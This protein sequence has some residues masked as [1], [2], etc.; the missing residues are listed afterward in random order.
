MFKA[1][2]SYDGLFSKLKCLVP[3]E[4]DAIKLGLARVISLKNMTDRPAF[5]HRMDPLSEAFG[6]MRIQDAIYTR[7]EA[8]APW[9]FSY[10]GDTV[11]R[12][13]FGLMVRGSGRG[14]FRARGAM[15]QSI[16]VGGI[17]DPYIFAYL[18]T[19]SDT[20]TARMEESK[21]EA[22]AFLNDQEQ[23]V[24]GDVVEALKAYDVT[25]AI[26][27]QRDSFVPAL[28]E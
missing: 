20:R 1:I 14:R 28:T 11:P 19:L 9:G 13:R 15:R 16:I 26:W 23:P 21:P 10:P 17:R 3:R 24:G 4:R 22:Y 2:R 12:I 27:S 18:W 7:L 25:P 8:T 5:E 6:S